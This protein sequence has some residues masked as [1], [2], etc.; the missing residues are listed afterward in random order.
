MLA[1]ATAERAVGRLSLDIALIIQVQPPLQIG[2]FKSNMNK[3][4]S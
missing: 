1:F 4:Y 3:C 2:R